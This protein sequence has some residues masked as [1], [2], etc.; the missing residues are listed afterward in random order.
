LFD[1]IE[2]R[3][4]EALFLSGLL[5]GVLNSV[6]RPVLILLTLPLTVYTLGF[7]L[8]VLNA[9]MLQLVAWSVA[10]FHIESFWDGFVVALFVSI[11]GFI[12][13]AM[14]GVNKTTIV[15]STHRD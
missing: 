15:R 7:F 12:V 8:L 3:T 5:L 9:L 13:S 4:P 2:F 14:I 1:R 6:L 10:D 11:F